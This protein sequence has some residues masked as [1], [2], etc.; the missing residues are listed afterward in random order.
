MSAYRT[1]SAPNTV[2]RVCRTADP[3]ALPAWNHVRA[4][5]RGRYDDPLDVFR[6]LYTSTSQVGA[7]TETLADLRPR[8]DCM[9][10][11]HEI[12]GDPERFGDVGEIISV[13]AAAMKERLKGRYLAAIRVVDRGPPVFVDLAAGASRGQLEYRLATSRLKTGHFTGR[14]RMLPRSA[15]RAVFDAGRYG[16]IMPSAECSCARTVALFETGHETNRYRVRLEVL[17]VVPA[18]R[19]RAAVTAAIRT[20][21]GMDVVSPLVIP[22]LLEAA[23]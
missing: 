8:F 21:L 1:V 2:Y 18:L 9:R 14:D 3:L 19:S 4:A 22:E 20:L 5:E 17:S 16:L 23:S 15:S 7:L 10:K 12:Q 11:I 13:A 6:V